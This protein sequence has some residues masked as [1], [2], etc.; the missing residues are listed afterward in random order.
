MLSHCWVSL[1]QCSAHPVRHVL[2]LERQQP[3]AVEQQRRVS[4]L[5]C[6]LRNNEVPFSD[7]EALRACMKL[8]GSVLSA[9]RW[10]LPWGRK[11]AHLGIQ[12]SRQALHRVRRN[13]QRA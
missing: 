9:S 7:I 13:A 11:Q 10:V 2:L 5:I 8:A 4:R 1:S 12:A 3:A 6:V